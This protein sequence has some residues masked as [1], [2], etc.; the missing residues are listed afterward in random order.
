MIKHYVFYCAEFDEIEIFSL[1]RLD[2]N[3]ALYLGKSYE[4]IGVL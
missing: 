1:R 2:S 4:L 3:Y